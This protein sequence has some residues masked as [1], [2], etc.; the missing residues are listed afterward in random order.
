LFVIND[1]A[2]RPTWAGASQSDERVQVT[3]SKLDNVLAELGTDARWMMV[4]EVVP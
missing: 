4:D 2:E 1:I 3:L